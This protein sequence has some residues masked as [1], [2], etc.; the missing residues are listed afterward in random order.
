LQLNFSLHWISRKS[1]LSRFL[2]FALTYYR[3]IL[4]KFCNTLTT[5]TSVFFVTVLLLLLSLTFYWTSF[6][7]AIFI[8]LYFHYTRNFIFWHKLGV[9][10]VKPTA[11]VGNLKDCVLLKTTRGEQLQRIYNEHSDKPYVG[12]FSFDKPSLLVCDLE[13]VKNILVKDFQTFAHGTFSAEKNLD[14]LFG[15]VLSAVRGQ[16]W[17]YLRT[18]L[19]SVFTSRKMKMMFYLVDTCG[20]ELA[21]CLEKVT[22]DGK[23]PKPQY[24]Y[25]MHWKLKVQ[26]L[27]EFTGYYTQCVPGFK[28]TTDCPYIFP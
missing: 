19:T 9:P 4:Q 11:F 5:N 6:I 15:N 23:L 28:V 20:K 27:E 13:L 7:A 8:G 22:A 10:Y 1:T 14:P 25:K 18:N 12:I 16:L 3:H 24:S 26:E 21:D 2:K 17:R